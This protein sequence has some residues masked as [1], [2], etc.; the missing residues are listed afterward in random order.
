MKII[1]TERQN[2]LLMED[3]PISLRRRINYNILKDHLLDFIMENYNPCDYSTLGDF[4]GEMCDMLVLDLIDDYYY[5]NGG[6]IDSKTKDDLYYF[7]VD[8]FADYLQEL[9]DKQ[10]T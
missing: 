2:N 9:Y 7:M 6:K 1:I 4:I 3:L 10:C 5:E 8:N